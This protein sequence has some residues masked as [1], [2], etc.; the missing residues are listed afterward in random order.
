MRAKGLLPA[1]CKPCSE[2]RKKVL[3]LHR[4]I[5]SCLNTGD[6]EVESPLQKHT[7]CTQQRKGRACTTCLRRRFIQPLLGHSCCLARV[8]KLQPKHCTEPI[9]ISAQKGKHFRVKTKMNLP[10]SFLCASS[11][12]NILRLNVFLFQQEEKKYKKRLSSTD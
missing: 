9:A 6:S 12:I 1:L 3:H 5:P 8:W 4:D 2:Q 11:K 10:H 7:F